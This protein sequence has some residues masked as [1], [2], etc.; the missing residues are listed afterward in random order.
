MS[1]LRK[2]FELE[3]RQIEARSLL[4]QRNNKRANARKNSESRVER[5]NFGDVVKNYHDN[6]S[7]T[8]N[9]MFDQSK[10]SANDNKMNHTTITRH[11]H[12]VESEA[13]EDMKA[14]TRASHANVFN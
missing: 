3:E 6:K 11:S 14:I 2:S 9:F 12:Q 1:F 8:E 5:P 4:A 13:M 7:G 10:Q